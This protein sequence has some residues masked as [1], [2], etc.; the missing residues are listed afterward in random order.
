MSE[1]KVEI[2]R[3]DEAKPSNRLQQL[4]QRIRERAHSLFEKRKRTDGHALDDWLQA[5]QELLFRPETIVEDRGDELRLTA[6][7]TDFKP[8]EIHIDALPNSIL[9][10]AEHL[11]DSHGDRVEKECVAQL[12]LPESID[13]K[14]VVAKLHHGRLEITATKLEQAAQTPA[15]L[16]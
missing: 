5:E 14:R 4:T 13:P 9:V 8:K 10:T 7:M 12:D 2:Y 3:A 15:A 6:D 16:S 11:E 1:I